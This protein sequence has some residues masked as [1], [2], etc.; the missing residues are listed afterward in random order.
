MFDEERNMF[1]VEWDFLPAAGREVEF[2][3]A[4]GPEGAWVELFRQGFG[5]LGTEL[6]ALAEKPGWYRTID[7]WASRESY[8][9]FRK[10]FADDYARIDATCEALTALEVQDCQA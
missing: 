9:A 5:Y 7:R 1:V 3:A 8:L 10:S 2:V 6:H 4:Y